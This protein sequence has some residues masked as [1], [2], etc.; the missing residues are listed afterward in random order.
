MLKNRL[1]VGSWNKFL[2]EYE[3]VSFEYTGAGYY[4]KIIAN[5]LNIEKET[6]H[7]PVVVAQ[8]EDFTVGF[9][10]FVDRNEIVM[11]CHSWSEFNPPENIRDLDITIKIDN[12][13]A[14]RNETH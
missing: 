12:D 9:L 2:K 6:I 1:S 8:N 7:N 14:A 10:L 11:E 13:L 5:H 3:L 4:L